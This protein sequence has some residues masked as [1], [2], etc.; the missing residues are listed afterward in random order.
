[1][2]RPHI[3][4]ADFITYKVTDDP[5][6]CASCAPTSPALAAPVYIK[7]KQ[8]CVWCAL[9][10]AEG[11]LSPG[12]KSRTDRMIEKARRRKRL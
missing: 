3:T 6:P 9:D 8:Y 1:M 12:G 11:L 5:A 10:I 4:A 7:D 2:K